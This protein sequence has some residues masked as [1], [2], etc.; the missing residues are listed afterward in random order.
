M[1]H[2]LGETLPRAMYI[3]NIPTSSIRDRQDVILPYTSHDFKFYLFSPQYSLKENFLR[4]RCDTIDCT[5]RSKEHLKKLWS[6]L[7]VRE[8]QF[9]ARNRNEIYAERLITLHY[10]GTRK[11]LPRACDKIHKFSFTSEYCRRCP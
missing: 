4:F 10:I 2:L 11:I 5:W 6:A 1:S 8:A 3:S 7:I 9:I